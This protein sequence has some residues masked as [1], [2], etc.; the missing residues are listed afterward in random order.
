MRSS[1]NKNNLDAQ[2]NDGKAPALLSV[3]WLLLL[4]LGQWIYLR[5][6]YPLG[7]LCHRDFIYIVC[8]HTIPQTIEERRR[9]ARTGRVYTANTSDL[10]DE[11]D[12]A[13]IHIYIYTFSTFDA[14]VN[15]ILAFFPGGFHQIPF[16]RRHKENSQKPRCVCVCNIYW[17]L[18]VNSGSAYCIY[19]YTFLRFLSDTHTHIFFCQEKDTRRM[20]KYIYSVAECALG[21]I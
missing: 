16:L 1:R 11:C 9:T 2:T 14:A 18:F 6:T 21:S 19:I 3:Y 4:L 12:I 7:T 17:W 15:L 8:T 10:C 5:C 13:Q 20:I